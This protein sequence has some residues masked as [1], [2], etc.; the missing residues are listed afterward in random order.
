MQT[1][2][3][4]CTSIVSIVCLCTGGRDASKV[5]MIALILSSI[6]CTWSTRGVIIRAEDS[7]LSCELSFGKHPLYLKGVAAKMSMILSI[8]GH[9]LVMES[10]EL[11][12]RVKLF[13]S[14]SSLNALTL[15]P[16]LRDSI[17]KVWPGIERL[18]D[19]SA[20]SSLPHS[21]FLL[22]MY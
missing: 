22:L 13:E 16:S 10:P 7:A 8:S 11:G 21:P 2:C 1:V 6:D 15:G 20:L 5:A 12:P 9:T 17:T 4:L 18:R 19:I 3:T 14:F